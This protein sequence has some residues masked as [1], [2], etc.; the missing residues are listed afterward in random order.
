MSK[1]RKNYTP[2]EKVGI[3]KQHTIIK[4]MVQG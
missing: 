1:K 2:E 3:L 4:D